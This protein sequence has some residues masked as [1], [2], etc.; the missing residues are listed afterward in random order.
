[1]YSNTGELQ[2]RT[3]GK[4]GPIKFIDK[5]LQQLV[6]CGTH[7]IGVFNTGSLEVGVMCENTVHEIQSL[8]LDVSPAIVFAGL[9]NGEVIVF[10]TRYSISNGPAYC[11]PVHRLVGKNFG[12]LASIKGHLLSL[13]NGVLT[14]FNTSFLEV[15]LVSIP[16]YYSLPT[17]SSVI[18]SYKNNNI[19]TVVIASFEQIRVYEILA[20][21]FL[22]KLQ[23]GFTFDFAYV[24]VIAV[25]LAVVFIVFWK[26]RGRKSKRD[27]EVEKLE[28]SL[29]EL[30]KSM[31]STSKISEDLTNRFK[32]VEET[33]KNLA[34]VRRI[35]EDD[36]DD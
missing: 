31:E 29:E 22:P 3:F 2:G 34:G 32:Y 11:K 35:A 36:F 16:Q 17:K 4:V 20:P 14:A 18:K 8:S 27:L 5:Y 26:S 6:F 24:R 15:E 23:T 13:N 30:H 33:T 7:K 21:V 25:V 10:D 12:S 28:Q 9:Q 19:N 1:M